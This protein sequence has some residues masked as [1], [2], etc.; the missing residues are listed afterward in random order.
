MKTKNQWLGLV[1]VALLG[2]AAAAHADTTYTIDINTAALASDS[3]APFSLDFALTQGTTTES[4]TAWIRNIVLTGGTATGTPVDYSIGGP[5]PTGDLVNGF[6]LTDGGPGTFPAGTSEIAQTFSPGV[7]DIQFT[8]QLTGNS[9][10]T[11]PDGFNISILDNSTFQIP[12]TNGDGISLA[13]FQIGN[14]TGSPA[15][16]YSTGEIVL[17]GGDVTITV[18]ATPEPASWA[19]GLLAIGAVVGL[20][21][22]ATGSRLASNE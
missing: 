11:T 19:L 7:T 21:R 8:L 13:S 15:T 6:T 2:S 22:L 16:T 12:T 5:S 4:N 1:A 3:N 17:D 20:R 9:T 14:A 18:T 10:G